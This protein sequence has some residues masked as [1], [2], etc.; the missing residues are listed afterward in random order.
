MQRE[1]RLTGSKRFSLIHQEGRRWANRLLLL[2]AI[3]NDLDKSR[4]GFLVGKRIGCA[5]VR[6][7]VKRRLREII[8][9]RAIRPGWD[10][11]LIA[12]REASKADYSQLGNAAEDLLQRAG[13]MSKPAPNSTGPVIDDKWREPSSED[14]SHANAKGGLAL[15]SGRPRGTEQ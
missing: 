13:L 5:V 8:R 12:R 7:K 15:F 3:A 2:R 11:L 9:V 4:F 14:K 1:L 10:I 6:N